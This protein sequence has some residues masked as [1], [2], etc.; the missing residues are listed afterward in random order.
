MQGI[1]AAGKQKAIKLVT[2][3]AEVWLRWMWIKRVESEEEQR[4][5]KQ[6]SR[7]SLTPT[8][9]TWTGVSETV[10]DLKHLITPPK[11]D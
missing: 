7:A 2:E 11:N 5:I 8:G 3:A 4:Y 1:R 10:R 6:Q 9:V